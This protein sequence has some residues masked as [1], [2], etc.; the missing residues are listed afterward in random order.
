MKQY[1]RSYC[2][3]RNIVRYDPC[4]RWNFNR[5]FYFAPRIDLAKKIYKSFEEILKDCE[6]AFSA[7]NGVMNVY[8]RGKL[9]FSAKNIYMVA[10]C[11]AFHNIYN[12]KKGFALKNIKCS[13]QQ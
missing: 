8:E 6:R 10:I 2:A 11:V 12:G 13:K 4:F 1:H 3:G 9:T 7:K 5:K